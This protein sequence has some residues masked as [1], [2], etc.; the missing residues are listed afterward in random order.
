MDDM[1]AVIKKCQNQQKS[2]YND[3]D[4]VFMVWTKADIN[5]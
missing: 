5:D 4:Y 3:N 1:E 2:I